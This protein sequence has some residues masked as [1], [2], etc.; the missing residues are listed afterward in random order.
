MKGAQKDCGKMENSFFKRR[1][2]AIILKLNSRSSVLS[3]VDW[4]REGVFKGALKFCIALNVS[5]SVIS[6]T[7]ALNVSSSVISIT[8]A[9]KM[10]VSSNS[11]I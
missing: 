1:N 6:I 3:P 11:A 10:L 8:L 5:I 2:W 9:N 7:L 4:G